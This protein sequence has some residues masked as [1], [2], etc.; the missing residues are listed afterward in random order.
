V[1]ARRR[2]PQPG[3][4]VRERP[5]RL[6]APGLDPDNGAVDPMGHQVTSV[7]TPRLV[8]RHSPG[9]HDR[10][11]AVRAYRASPWR[12]AA[13]PLRLPTRAPS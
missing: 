8:V 9:T 11:P 5:G 12:S 7:T 2:G 10:T 6:G 3:Q 1:E 4:A 13:D